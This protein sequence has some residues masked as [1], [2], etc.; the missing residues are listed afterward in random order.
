M[1]D[2]F[3]QDRDGGMMNKALSGVI[4]RLEKHP[5]NDLPIEEKRELMLKDTSGWDND[6][7]SWPPEPGDEE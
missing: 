2:K 4:Q 7:E 5:R 6:T 3:K 1:H